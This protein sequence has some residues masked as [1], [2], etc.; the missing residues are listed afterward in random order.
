MRVVVN[1]PKSLSLSVLRAV[2]EQSFPPHFLGNLWNWLP[3][4]ASP[5][6]QLPAVNTHSPTHTHTAVWCSLKSRKGLDPPPPTP[7]PPLPLLLKSW[8]TSLCSQP[9]SP[10]GSFTL[11]KDER[12]WRTQTEQ[13]RPKKGNEYQAW[14]TEEVALLSKV[15]KCP[16]PS[17]PENTLFFLSFNLFDSDFYFYF[18]SLPS[19][20]LSWNEFCRSK[21]EWE[22][23]SLSAKVRQGYNL[24]QNGSKFREFVWFCLISGQLCLHPWKTSKTTC[25]IKRL[26]CFF[27]TFA[28]QYAEI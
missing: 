10:L 1:S 20:S 11:R 9:A 2:L 12:R 24:S 14:R 28:L 15:S 13:N 6:W 23:V 17:E 16:L 4:Q 27:S 21:L 3:C 26:W 5:F 19:G 7:T 18:R 8:L 25:L 22:F